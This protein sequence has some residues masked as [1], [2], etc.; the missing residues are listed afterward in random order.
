MHKDLGKLSA[1][2]AAERLLGSMLVRETASGSVS[3]IIVETE[4][5]DQSDKASHTYRGLTN[6]NYV[7]FGPAGSSYVYFT[8]GMHYCVNVVVGPEGMGA[9]VLLRA[10]EPLTGIELMA[11][12]RLTTDIRKIC[13]GPA[14]ICQAFS[15]NKELNGHDLKKPPL[16][17][18]L[19]DPIATK[20]IV[21]TERIGIRENKTL[22]WR[23]CIKDSPFVS[24]QV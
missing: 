13:N 16:Y 24:R 18:E 11:F 12:R 14:K 10:I 15:I 4:A 21:W 2:D 22:L 7:M 6:R 8:Y 20:K 19:N 17:L 1:R 23:A 3:G 9:S 5:Y